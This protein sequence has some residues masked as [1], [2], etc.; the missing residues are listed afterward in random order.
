LKSSL[1]EFDCSAEI[2]QTTRARRVQEWEAVELNSADGNP[3]SPH[4]ISSSLLDH[5]QVAHEP[6][7]V[8]DTVA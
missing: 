6:S 2:M 8:E 1:G 5:G 4:T 3:A 7:V